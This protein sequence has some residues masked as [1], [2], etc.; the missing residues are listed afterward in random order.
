MK[1]LKT[2]IRFDKDYGRKMIRLWNVYEQQW[3]L[4]ALD[5]PV[6]A[7]VLAS[8]PAFERNR[9]QRAQRTAP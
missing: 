9:I 1:N 8:L 7:N 2:T 3:K 6:P 5:E 4:Y